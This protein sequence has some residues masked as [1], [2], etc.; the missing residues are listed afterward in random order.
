MRRALRTPGIRG[1]KYRVEAGTSCSQGGRRVDRRSPP[2]ETSH[3][4][5]PVR[6]ALRRRADGGAVRPSPAP[7]PRNQASRWHRGDPE[8]SCLHPLHASNSCVSNRPMP[9]SWAPVDF[10]PTRSRVHRLRGGRPFS[11]GI[12]PCLHPPWT[13]FPGVFPVAFPKSAAREGG[14][15][16]DCGKPATTR[17][18]TLCPWPR[19]R[20]G[21]GRPALLTDGIHGAP[22]REA[23][24]LRH[25]GAAPRP[26]SRTA[27]ARPNGV[28][29]ADTGFQALSAG[30]SP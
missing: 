30:E 24:P 12:W 3:T 16:P 23:P 8:S 18:F 11:R 17:R 7:P 21:P 27:P 28:G 25:T 19:L 14:V 2:S 20:G 13:A 22:G 15:H 9:P 6:D 5:R 4:A 10:S 26:G 29:R 1:A